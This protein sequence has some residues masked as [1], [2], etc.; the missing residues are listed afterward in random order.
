M[1]HMN[2]EPLKGSEFAEFVRKSIVERECCSGVRYCIFH[3]VKCCVCK[4]GVSGSMCHPQLICFEINK[5]LAVYLQ[6]PPLIQGNASKKYTCIKK[7]IR[8]HQ[9]N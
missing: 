7:K 3:S 6:D 4:R 9:K 1:P 8:L 2:L 5:L